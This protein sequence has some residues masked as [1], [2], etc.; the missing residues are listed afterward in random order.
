MRGGGGAKSKKPL[1]D[2][3][4]SAKNIILPGGEPSNIMHWGVLREYLWGVALG[5]ALDLTTLFEVILSSKKKTL[6]RP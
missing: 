1:Q 3:V 6:G 2:K 5:P 4:L